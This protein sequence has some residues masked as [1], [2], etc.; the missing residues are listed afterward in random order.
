MR[1]GGGGETGRRTGDRHSRVNTHSRIKSG[2]AEPKPEEA[3]VSDGQPVNWGV[4][5]G[6]EGVTIG[7]MHH[8][9]FH[10]G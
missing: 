7:A 3:R 6:V 4:S 9:L 2:R 1:A 10:K 5:V 8:Q